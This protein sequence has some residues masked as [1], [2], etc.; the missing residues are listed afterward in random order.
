MNATHRNDKYKV[1]LNI[2]LRHVKT[3]ALNS[4]HQLSFKVKLLLVKKNT[5]LCSFV[6]FTN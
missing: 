4:L 5:F 3:Y 1:F 6:R 2:E